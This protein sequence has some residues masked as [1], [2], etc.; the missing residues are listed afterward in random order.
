M[1]ARFTA[2]RVRLA[3]DRGDARVIND[4]NGI[5]LFVGGYGFYFEP[6]IDE[7]SKTTDDYLASHSTDEIARRAA[8]ALNN[9]GIDD[10]Q[11]YDDEL[12]YYESVL[13]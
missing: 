10:P 4:G 7:E 9:M 6:D 5:R 13:G 12:A 2:E 8:V 11:T 1:S 3:M